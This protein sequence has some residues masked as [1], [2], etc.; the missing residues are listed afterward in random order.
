MQ[1]HPVAVEQPSLGQ[2]HG[3]GVD[4]TQHHALVI[5]LAQ[6]VLQDRAEAAQWLE[7]GHHQQGR[8][9]AQRLQRGVGIHRHAVAGRHRTAIHTQH[10]PAVQL[11][12]K[13]VGHPQRLYRGNEANG[14]ET[15]QQQEIEIL[16]HSDNSTATDAGLIARW[17][18]LCKC[19]SPQ[20]D[21]CPGYPRSLI[22]RHA[23]AAP[24]NN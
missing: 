6:P 18:P 14:G 5:E 13:A 10:L 17:S 22:T 15:G 12:A 7:T 19:R 23:E 8:A 2:H 11:A 4:A 20:C 16:G 3:A 21:F 9:F 1:G 24:Y